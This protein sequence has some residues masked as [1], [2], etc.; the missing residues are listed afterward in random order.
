MTLFSGGS[1]LTQKEHLIPGEKTFLAKDTRVPDLF[2]LGY[3]FF[4]LIYFIFGITGSSAR[5]LSLVPVS[6]GHSLVVV[7]G[8]LIAV[9]SL[10]KS[11]LSSVWASVAVVLGL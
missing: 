8:L 5:G 9:A 7:G 11:R 3:L 4:F 10:V 6:R 1:S 2:A